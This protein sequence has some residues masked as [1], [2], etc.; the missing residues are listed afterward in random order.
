MRKK[1]LVN[2]HTLKFLEIL[3][4]E[5]ELNFFE[6]NLFIWRE[7]KLLN[8]INYGHKVVFKSKLLNV[9]RRKFL[10]SPNFRFNS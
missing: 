3:R 6:T 8:K 2:R 1:K 4:N 9:I 7:R 10:Y 5:L